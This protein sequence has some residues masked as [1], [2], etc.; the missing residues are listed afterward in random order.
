MS[1]PYASQIGQ[2]DDWSPLITNVMMLE[3]PMLAWLPAGRE[4][5][6]ATE[7][8]QAETWRNPERNSHPD[9]VP[10]GNA[11][12]A[13]ETRVPIEA[14]IQYST[15]RADVTALT[16]HAGNVAGVPDELGKEIR[17]QTKELANDIECAIHSAQECRVGV[18]GVTGFM[19]RGV[20]N[21]IQTTAQSVKPVDSTIRPAAAQV[22]T[23]ATASFTEDMVLNILQGVFTTTRSREAITAFVAPTAKRLINKWPSLDGASTINGGAYPTPVRGGAFDRNI[24][25]Y[26]SPFGPVDLVLD[27][28]N[29]ALDSNGVMQSGTTYNTH[30]IFFLHQSK[31]KFH[32]G[33]FKGGS[34]SPN[35]IKSPYEGGKESAFC[36]TVWRLTCLNP[37]GEAKY[38]PAS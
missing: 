25:R 11:K 26:E 12:S 19:T 24:M 33:V 5:V 28:N 4:I 32:Y 8:Y 31:W 10:V 23:T 27:A 29:Y 14:V 6:A 18:T 7:N 16:Q 17:K 34:G 9:G 30:S 22:D 36:E 20:P 38:A 21:W 15:K 1:V 13:G 37:Q 3:Q 2:Q 35:W